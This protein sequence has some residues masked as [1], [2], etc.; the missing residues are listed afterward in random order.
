LHQG[1]SV[2]LTVGEEHPTMRATAAKLSA[3]VRRYE[4]DALELE[5]K[6]LSVQPSRHH[7]EYLPDENH[8]SALHISLYKALKWF[9]QAPISEH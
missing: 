6:R 2:Y 1:A 8:A 7:F 9:F 4:F 5:Q 3:L